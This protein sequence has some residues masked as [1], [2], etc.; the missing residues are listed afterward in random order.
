MRDLPKYSIG[1][2]VQITKYGHIIWSQ[3]D[4]AVDMAPELVG[5]T[6]IVSN[7]SGPLLYSDGSNRWSYAL[8]GPNKHAWYQEDQLTPAPFRLC[9]A[10]SRSFTDQ[11]LLEDEVIRFL[12]D[13]GQFGKPLEIVSGTAKGADT[14]GEIFAN[15]FE[16]SITRFPADWSIGKKAGYLRNKEM[17]RYSDA[18]IVFWDGTSNGTKNMISITKANNKPLRIIEYGKSTSTQ[19]EQNSDR[20]DAPGTASGQDN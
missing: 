17:A 9:I 5:Q 14:L 7:I 10:G 8:E 4:G 16:H 20:T 1:D 15:D 13:L 19:P 3:K 11:G 18:V 6:G 2:R 12:L